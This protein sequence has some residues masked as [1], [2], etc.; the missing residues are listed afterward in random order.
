MCK[1]TLFPFV[2]LS[3]SVTAVLRF[4]KILSVLSS[5]VL[6]CVSSLQYGTSYH[7]T[8]C[9]HV[10][11]IHAKKPSQMRTL[12]NMAFLQ[13]SIFPLEIKCPF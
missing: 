1:D 10:K 4:I 5:S 8:S 2:P 9:F 7:F 12:R 3:F 6:I 11:V 13:A